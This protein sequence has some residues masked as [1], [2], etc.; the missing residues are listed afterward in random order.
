[1]PLR[2][3][4]MTENNFTYNYILCNQWIYF[5]KIWRDDKLY[6][7][8]IC[9]W[10]SRGR[11]RMVVAFTT[12]CAIS[13]YHHY[14][15]EFESRSWRSV[16]ETTLCNKVCQWLV[17]GRWFSPDTLVSST[18]KTDHLD[19]TEILLKVALSIINLKIMSFPEEKKASSYKGKCCYP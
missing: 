15:F 2:K 7:P 18:N 12:T 10:G 13:V 14:C 16:L 9:T 8:L 11:D 17:T 6:S 5:S 4:F 3:S 1:L 19:I